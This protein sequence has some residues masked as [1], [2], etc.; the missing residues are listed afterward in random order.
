MNQSRKGLPEAK[1]K[2]GTQNPQAVEEVSSGLLWEQG[3][4]R[5]AGRSLV[6]EAGLR[7]SAR[8]GVLPKEAASERLVWGE[9]HY[10]LSNDY[11]QCLCV[12]HTQP[13][14]ARNSYSP[15]SASGVVASQ[16]GAI[17]PSSNTL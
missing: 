6:R 16:A 3:Q 10:L 7:A 15:A 12:S 17:I 14:L 2:P 11:E 8:P 9:G 13:R 1:G 5:Q 4:G